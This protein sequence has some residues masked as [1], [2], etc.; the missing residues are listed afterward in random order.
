MLVRTEPTHVSAADLYIRVTPARSA[1]K[2]EAG[3]NNHF[4]I[5]LLVG[6]D[7][8]R[9]GEATLQEEFSTS[10][11][12]HDVSRSAERSREY[13]LKTSLA[14]IEN[15]VDLY[16]GQASKLP[17][18]LTISQQNEIEKEDGR[19]AK[20][21]Y[22]A[23]R[24]GFL[25][26]PEL[27]LVRLGF[28]WRN[29]VVHSEATSK[30]NAGVRVDLLKHAEYFA[31]HYRGLDIRDSLHSVDRRKAPRFKEVASIIAASQVLV[32]SFDSALLQKINVREYANLVLRLYIEEQ[33]AAGTSNVFPKL[34]PG[35][36]QKSEE[37]I[38]QILRQKGF[39]F[40][41]EGLARRHPDQG[42]FLP[43]EYMERLAKADVPGAK[44]ELLA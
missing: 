30:L 40:G 15:L 6:L 27:A 8:V 17:N 41:Q 38:T 18:A 32:K 31:Q 19:S 25:D 12:P 21:R 16:R 20:L 44:V 43:K 9:R 39:T 13:A 22:F 37:R 4:L 5:T 34:W 35:S 11:S 10:W 23:T 2:R 42:G 36:P 29:L 26:S 28:H 3:Q 7:S 33:I 24:L 14:W 1:F